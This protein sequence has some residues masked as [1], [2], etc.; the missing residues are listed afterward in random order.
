MKY[1]VS[2]IQRSVTVVHV[3]ADNE[4][5]AEATAEAK[6]L[7]GEYGEYDEEHDDLT[8]EVLEEDDY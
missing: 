8:I 3:E 7:R 5:A 1:R 4:E 6:W 2:I